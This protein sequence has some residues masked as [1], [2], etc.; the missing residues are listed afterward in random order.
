VSSP[1]KAIVERYLDGFRRSDHEQVLS[2]L[3]GDVRWDMPG[4]F[5]LEG[6]EAFDAAIENDAFT[7]HP[8]ITV[9]RMVEEDDTV[10]AIG[11]VRATLK[12]GRALRAVFCDVFTFAGERIARLETYQVT[13]SPPPAELQAAMA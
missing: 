6:R 7:G 5:A 13:L 12:D 11:A 2:C 4:F 10:V 8:E 3:T 1:R 9:D